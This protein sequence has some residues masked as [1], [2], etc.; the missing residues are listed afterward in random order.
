MRG[1][2]PPLDFTRVGKQYQKDGV[3]TLALHVPAA[4]CR[5][6]WRRVGVAGNMC[7]VCEQTHYKESGM[8]SPHPVPLYAL[9]E[10]PYTQQSKVCVVAA[11]WAIQKPTIIMPKSLLFTCFVEELLI[12]PFRR[13]SP[14]S[15]RVR[16]ASKVYSVSI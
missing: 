5:G 7:K 10:L 2:Q 9:N 11:D 15:A 6:V 3:A 8:D 4:L 16:K 13:L 12:T 14:P 1:G